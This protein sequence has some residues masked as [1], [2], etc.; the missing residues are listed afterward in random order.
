MRGSAAL[1][2]GVINLNVL[3]LGLMPVYGWPAKRKEPVEQ[4]STMQSDDPQQSRDSRN[5]SLT[6]LDT[7][8]AGKEVYLS[9]S[10]LAPA[11][12]ALVQSVPAPAQ[13]GAGGGKSATVEGFRIQCFAS[14]QIENARE[15][16]RKLEQ[17]TS[18]PIYILFMDPYYKILVGD[19]KTRDAAEKTRGDLKN[20]G[21]KDAWIMASPINTP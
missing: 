4:E 16:K 18:L 13:A 11:A 5:Y 14:A 9:E 15:E 2:W 1:R 17:K 19:F 10:E 3:I 8:N 7:L 20:S 6:N 12:A 21:Y